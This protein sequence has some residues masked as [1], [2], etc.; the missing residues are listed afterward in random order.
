M[1]HRR[2]CQSGTVSWVHAHV[3]KNRGRISA[4]LLK[5]NIHYLFWSAKKKYS[6]LNPID[7]YGNK[8]ADYDELIQ[9]WLE[10]WK[11]EDIE[12]PEKLEPLLIKTLIA[13]ESTF[14]PRVKSKAKG[15]TASGLMQ[16]TD[17]M[18][19]VLGGFPNK[20]DYIEQRKSLIHVKYGDKLDPVVNV[21]LGIRLLGHKYSKIPKGNEKSL[22]NTVKNYHSRDKGGDAYAKE[23][24]SKYEKSLKKK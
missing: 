23:V 20:D 11:S 19:R 22:Y 21:A 3:R 8:G 16:V 17:Q 14:D 13:I 12:F 5:E 1:R 4:G 9:F 7:G 6:A 2:V 18:V 15:S 24:F 10:Y